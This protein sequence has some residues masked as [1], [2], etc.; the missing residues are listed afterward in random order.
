MLVILSPK[1]ILSASLIK[2][3]D[4]KINRNKKCHI[5]KRN[6]FLYLNTILSNFLPLYLLTN[7]SLISRH[8][9]LVFALLIINNECGVL[10]IAFFSRKSLKLYTK[11]LSFV[12]RQLVNHIIALNKKGYTEIIKQDFLF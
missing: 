8:C 11:Y 5:W 6:V 2:K 7:V 3:S 12:F 4:S 10:H 9:Q 1:Y